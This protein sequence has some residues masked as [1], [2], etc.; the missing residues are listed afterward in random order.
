MSSLTDLTAQC[1]RC[2]FCLESCP[3]FRLSGKETEGPRGR[4][5]LVRSAEETILDWKDI[6]QDI[7]SCLGCRACETACPSGVKYGDIFEAAKDQIEKADPN[8]TKKLFLTGLTNP[9]LLETQIML[10]KLLPGRRIPELLSKL[11]SGESPE[12]DLP[13]KEDDTPWPDLDE[14]R[15]PAIKGE[16]ALLEGCVMRVLY[17]PVHEATKRLL[18]R[19]GYRTVPVQ[20]TCCGAL[21]AHNGFLEE[22]NKKSKNLFAELDNA[23]PVII[24]SAGCGSWTKEQ[25]AAINESKANIKD[26]TEFLLANGLK[27]K[28]T[29]TS[30]FNVTLT[31]HDACHLSHGQG[32]RNQPR[33]LLRAI[34]RAEYKELQ[35]ADTCCGSAGIYNLTQPKIARQL[36]DQKWENIE[37]TTAQ[38]VA[39]GNPGCL[40]WIEQASREH[41]QRV[42]VMHTLEVLESS[43]SGL[44]WTS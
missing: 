24:N 34:P 26:A 7:D 41:G 11:L 22:A 37:T 9:T 35:D 38:I 17:N 25:N 10:G 5:Y 27:E 28:L 43:F 12:A 3:T 39:T 32:I 23:T 30:G 21:H 4:I 14:R 31:Y 8:K 16:V 1:I 13:Q 18:R 20:T 6:K 44:R 42:K 29:E 40:A 15:L 19:V 36:L 33:E 2:G